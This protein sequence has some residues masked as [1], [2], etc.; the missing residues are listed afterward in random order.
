MPNSTDSFKTFYS[1]N[2][3]NDINPIVFIHGVGLNQEMW[4]PQINFFKNYTTLTY[5]FLGHGKTLLEK[6]K[7]TFKELSEQLNS[8]ISF[9][10]LGKIHLIGFSMG[11]LIARNFSLAYGDKLK[12]LTIF[13]STYQRTSEQRKKVMYRLKQTKLSNSLSNEALKRWFSN[14]FLVKNPKIYKE[15]FG[16]LENN[17]HKNFIKAYE[18]FA[19][20]R[21]NDDLGKIKTKTLIMTGENDVGSTPEMSMNL[22]KKI[23]GSKYVEI[24][25]GKHLCSIECPDDVNMTLKQFIDE[26][27]A[28]T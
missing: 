12:S 7:L 25:G 4:K 2:K 8:L 9:L 26:N 14:E 13:G 27:N 23:K 21:D 19:N 16:M 18:L 11:A 15:I 6:E 10:D 17:N 20:Y 28:Q 3:T 5:D 1:L 24:K 22:S